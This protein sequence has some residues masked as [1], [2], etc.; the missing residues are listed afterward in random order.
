M[1][2]GNMSASLAERRGNVLH[3]D[4]GFGITCGLLQVSV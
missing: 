3:D 2:G 4:A 1:E